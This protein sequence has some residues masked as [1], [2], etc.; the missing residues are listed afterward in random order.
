MSDHQRDHDV[1]PGTGR[2]LLLDALRNRPTPRPA[3][4]PFAG[5]H[6]GALTNTDA[7][8]VLVDGDALL[9]SLLEVQRIYRPDGMP[10]LFD[11]QLEAECLGCELLWADD[12]PPTVRT[13]PLLDED[14]P[15]DRVIPCLCTLP[16]A[17]S[18]RIPLVLDVMRRLRA[19]VG[20]ETA[21]FGLI[22]GPFTLASHLRGNELFMDMYDDEDYT[23]QLMDFC[24]AVAWAMAELYIEA[25]MDVIALVDPLISQ[26]SE[27]HFRQFMTAPYTALFA[28]I[29]EAGALSSFFVCGDATRNIEA[30]CETKP[31]SIFVD[32]NVDLV[33]ARRIAQR[34]G[35]AT[36]GNIPLTSVM[37]HGSQLDNIKYTVDLIDRLEAETGSLQGAII[38]PGCDMPYA[39]P[40]ENTIGVAQAVLEREEMRELVR[41]HTATT[42]DIEVE[43]PDYGALERPL[44][45]VFTLDSA[46]CAA[47][48]YM[49]G[50]ARQV[51]DASGLSFDL[52]EYK[53]T[54]REN[55][56][57]CRAMGVTNLPSIYINGALAFSSIIPNKEELVARIREAGTADA[58]ASS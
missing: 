37:L 2:A 57:R 5:V 10:V 36:G 21:L 35:I 17:E 47:C 29:R 20:E 49:W 32:E 48:T 19:E 4:V 6:A 3:W 14:D 25:G 7:R 33:A 24:R 9:A 27:E 13:H 28:A 34:Y 56:A 22:C 23:V 30:M 46:T 58:R 44:V 52:V 1:R 18:G 50:A 42:L 54:E 53:Y 40:I 16:T 8:G 15:E 31:D 45:E 43:L 55:I 38:A 41:D 26:I 51:H 11:L 12:A 39:I